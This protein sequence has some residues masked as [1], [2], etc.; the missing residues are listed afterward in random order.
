YNTWKKIE[1]FAVPK[2]PHG[3]TVNGIIGDE[4][5]K[6][7]GVEYGVIRSI[8]LLRSF[9]VPEKKERFILYQ[10]AVN[11]GR[12]FETL[13]PAMK[14]VDAKLIICGNGNFMAEAVRLVREQA[15]QHKIIF[16]GQLIPED[17]IQITRQAYIGLT[18]FDK[19]GLSNYYSLANRFFDYIHALVPQVC[20]DYPAY[21]EINN[22][23][24]VAVLIAEPDA[25]SIAKAINLLLADADLYKNLQDGC[26]LASQ[27]L[28]WQNEERKLISFYKIV[29]ESN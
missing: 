24:R 15:L 4:F 17:L 21:S 25:V 9:D 28:N 19:K 6:M 12:S 10:G 5:K 13:I 1:K 7:Y 8:S 3:Y 18:L 22:L 16:R 27:V 11:E 29:L 23:H 26:R 14:D 20:V 2:F